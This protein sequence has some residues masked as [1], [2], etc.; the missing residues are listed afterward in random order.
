LALLAALAG[1]LCIGSADFLGGVAAR[2]SHP[3]I[4]T[5]GINVVALALLAVAF[6]AVRP[7]LD[8]G[9]AVGALAGGI[10]SAAA[11]SLIYASLAAG[12]M[13]LTAPLIA[14]G[15]ALVPTAAAIVSGDA[16]S[17]A[18]AIGIALVLAGI[19]AITSTPPG[20]S[21]HVP[22]TRGALALTG[23]ASVVGG[24]AFAILLHAVE[25][26]DTATAV[27][28]AGVSR[29][30]STAVCLAVLALVFR[31]AAPPRPPARAV[32]GG[33][34]M[35]SAGTT[36]FLTAATLGEA[37]VTAVVV[38]LYAVVTVLLA[39]A[40]LRERVARHQGVGLAAAAAGVALLSAG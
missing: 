16:P 18:Q 19:V 2:R 5:A 20:A 36:C 3:L 15:S 10:V 38:S 21:D 32:L 37:A 14:C 28:V 7:H 40:V 30:A 25:S 39:Q 4:A 22:L 12:A 34:A 33:G 24:A 29:L 9:A 8:T 11:L 31:A 6:A 27:G 1:A 23:A 35:E 13:S 17:G 26:G